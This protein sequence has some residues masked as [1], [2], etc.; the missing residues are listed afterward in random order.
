MPSIPGGSPAL[1]AHVRMPLGLRRLVLIGVL[2]VLAGLLVGPFVFGV[3]LIA[4][5]GAVLIAVSMS[6]DLKRSGMALLMW[7]AAVA[8]IIWIGATVAY[9]WV[10]VSTVET[11]S[12]QRAPAWVSTLFIV[13]VCGFGIMLAT[14]VAASARRSIQKR[15]LVEVKESPQ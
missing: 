8:G 11:S 6:Y 1:Q 9:W 15:R 14:A 5:A 10:V 13:G 7:V 12:P 2:S 4:L 3:Q